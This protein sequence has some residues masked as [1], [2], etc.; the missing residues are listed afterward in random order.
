MGLGAAE[1][2]VGGDQGEGADV[3]AELV[4]GAFRPLRAAAAQ[5]AQL[6]SEKS[7]PAKGTS[8]RRDPGPRHRFGVAADRAVE[9]A[10]LRGADRRRARLRRRGS[11]RRPTDSRG[12]WTTQR[13]RTSIAIAASVPPTPPARSRRDQAAVGE[14][15]PAADDQGREPGVG[16]LGCRGDRPR[17]E[18]WLIVCAVAEGVEAEGETEQLEDQL[19]D[20]D[21]PEPD[22]VED[23]HEGRGEVADRVGD[24]GRDEDVEAVVGGR[25]VATPGLPLASQLRRVARSRIWPS[26][27]QTGLRM[28]RPGERVDL[29]RSAEFLGEVAGA[30]LI[31][32]RSAAAVRLGGWR[33]GRPW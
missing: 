24:P 2:C 3:V 17:R 26:W 11:A 15:D 9:R 14:P 31:R 18:I 4:V 20:E 22:P 19:E 13:P 23:R 21:Q 25:V 6:T 1:L 33:V 27:S 28:P 5:S 10:R 12:W 8:T 29:A 30:D 32:G 7:R 16:D